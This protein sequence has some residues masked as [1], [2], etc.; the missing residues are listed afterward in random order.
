MTIDH[1]AMKL[2][3]QRARHDPRTLQLA[4][5]IDSTLLPPAPS[6]RDWGEHIGAD[7]GM[8][9]NDHIGD[10]TSAAAAH[11]VQG[12]T[13]NNK[14]TVTV[15]D[16]LILAAYEALTGYDPTTGKNDTGAVE[17]DVLNYW[18]HNGIAGH[19]IDAYV[20]LEPGNRDH[21][22]DAVNLFGGCYIGLAMPLSAQSQVTWKIPPGGAHGTGAPASWGGHTVAVVAYNSRRVTCVTWGALKH[23]T[24]AFFDAYCDEA[25]AVLSPDWF[26]G[27]TA[28]VGFDLKTLQGDLAQLANAPLPTGAAG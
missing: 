26:S 25:Y 18:R 8:M 13:S 3:K 20:A 14:G 10:C 15:G 28:P 1:S 4:D 22:R 12:W 9:L 5:Y 24:W 2:G 16:P 7:W 11:L 23:M 21:V 17:T 6:S 19:S 27:M